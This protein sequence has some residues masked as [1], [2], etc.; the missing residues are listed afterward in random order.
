MTDNASHL[1]ATLQDFLD[2]RLDAAR[3]AEVRAHLEGCAQCRGELEAVRWVRDVALKQLPTQ[4]VPPALAARVAAALNAAHEQ[5]ERAGGRTVGRRWGRWAGAGALLAAAAVAFL[6]VVKP[7]EGGAT[8]PEAAARDFTAYRDGTLPLALH[9]SDGAAVEAL[10]VSAGLP[11][12]TRVFDLG[13]M[14]YQLQ[15]GLVHRLR[16][17]P[18]ALY[19]YRGPEGSEVVCQMFPGRLAELP[20]TADVREHDGIAFHVYRV[21]GVTLVFWQEGGVVCVLASDAESEA[22]IRLAYAKAVRV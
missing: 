1:G 20:R 21:E 17:R 11:F 14:H 7:G 13:M 6:L 2:G 4:D 9:T 15:G 12:T 5:T 3:Q 10:F 16:G 22:V 8:L 18:S 19:V